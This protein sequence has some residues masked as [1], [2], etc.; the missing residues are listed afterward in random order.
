M[1]K[2]QNTTQRHITHHM[3]TH[4]N[5][6]R[7]NTS[8]HNTTQTYPKSPKTSEDVTKVSEDFPNNSELLKKY[9]ML[10]FNTPKSEISGT[11]HPVLIYFFNFVKFSFFDV[12]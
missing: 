5:T 12:V 4:H 3:T 1:N 7:H 9:S 8:Q 11:C 10:H 2:R 6:T